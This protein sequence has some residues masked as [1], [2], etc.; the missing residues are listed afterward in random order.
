MS[1]KKE[2][3]TAVSPTLTIALKLCH[4]ELCLEGARVPAQGERPARLGG[5][6]RLAGSVL[7]SRSPR[8]ALAKSASCLSAAYRLPHPSLPPR[9][10]AVQP[11]FVAHECGPRLAGATAGW[12][13]QNV[14]SRPVPVAALCCTSVMH[15]FIVA[16]VAICCG[17]PLAVI[18]ITRKTTWVMFSHPG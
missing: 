2:W 16:S 3:I 18:I 15:L 1:E 13:Y 10:E 6:S 12:Q 14:R 7:D 9:G 5:A 8:G 17:T 11:A 4:K